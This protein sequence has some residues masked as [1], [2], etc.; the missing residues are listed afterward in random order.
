MRAVVA[1]AVL[2]ASLALS[3][4]DEANSQSPAPTPL[5]PAQPAGTTGNNE[6]IVPRGNEKPSFDCTQA[7]TAAARLI[8]ADAELARL[9]GELGAAFQKRKAQI[10]APDQSKFVAEE[11]AWIRDRNTR[12]DLVG[13]NTAATEV[14]ASS[15]QCMASMVRARIAV[16]SQTDLATDNKCAKYG[17]AVITLN[18]VVSVVQAYG[19]PNYGEDPAHDAKEPFNK[20]TVKTPICVAQG[21]DEFEPGVSEAAEFQLVFGISPSSPQSFPS[22]LLGKPVT[23]RGKLFHS[24][25]GH[26][27]TEVLID[28][29]SIGLDAVA[30]GSQSSE[31]AV[32]P[33]QDAPKI[34][35]GMPYNVARA[36]I[37]ST[38]WQA[39]VF[40]KSILAEIHRDL[41]EWFVDAG[42]MEIEDCSPTGS[43]FCVAEFHDAEGKRKLYVFTT[44]GS[45]DEI[46]Y[47]GHDPQIVS[48]CIDKKTVNCEQPMDTD[49]VAAL[50]NKHDS[51]AAASPVA[52]GKPSN[53]QRDDDF[54]H[55]Y[56]ILQDSG[57]K[58][59]ATGALKY[60]ISGWHQSLDITL[61]DLSTEVASVIINGA[62][63]HTS[64]LRGEWS[65]RVY[66]V[67]GRLAGEC[68]FTRRVDDVLANGAVSLEKGLREQPWMEGYLRAAGINPRTGPM[69]PLSPAEARCRQIFDRASTE[70]IDRWKQELTQC[71]ADLRQEWMASH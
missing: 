36:I 20:L 23:I 28:V 31:S 5:T 16:L 47:A 2:V 64:D 7:K 48:F 25:T 69:P 61:T 46:K 32:I 18:G 21:K 27:R 14:L 52:P 59:V 1:F 39:S 40:K 35:Q 26:H 12:C 68:K 66:L 62:C 17:P 3:I 15:K 45:R 37:L 4:P 33:Q 71:V 56:K 44:S 34:K 70:S 50:L 49:Q 65:I 29:T 6:R 58:L 24:E 67:D 63:N 57:A 11:L 10:S 41:Q 55:D 30:A 51:M 60:E 13:K 9:D 43:A 38:G 22:Q 19:P 8:C 53:K 54:D 42:F